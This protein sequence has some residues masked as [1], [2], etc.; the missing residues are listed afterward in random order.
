MAT[1]MERGKM[2]LACQKKP[3]RLLGSLDGLG[4]VRREEKGAIISVLID[5]VKTLNR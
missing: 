5:M 4:C 2:D 3:E 1:G